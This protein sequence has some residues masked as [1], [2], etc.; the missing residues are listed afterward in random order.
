MDP[1]QLEWFYSYDRSVGKLLRI[2]AVI[3][4]GSNSAL[5]KKRKNL[6]KEINLLHKDVGDSNLDQIVHR[7]CYQ[8]LQYV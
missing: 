5:Q 6:S 7:T 8:Y 4:G 3:A 1:Y 2:C